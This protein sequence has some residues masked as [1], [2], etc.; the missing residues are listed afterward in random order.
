MIGFAKN[1][2]DYAIELLKEG[3]EDCQKRL[4]ADRANV[5]TEDTYF[6]IRMVQ[7]IESAKEAIKLLES[8]NEKIDYGFNTKAK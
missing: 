7:S 1:K 4:A 5:Y 6:G 3:M 2:F 8:L